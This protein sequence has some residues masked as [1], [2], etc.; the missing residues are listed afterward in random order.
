M[1]MSHRVEFTDSMSL[2]IVRVNGLYW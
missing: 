1:G 2:N